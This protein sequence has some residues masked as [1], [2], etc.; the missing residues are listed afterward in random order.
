MHSKILN[1]IP[2][3]YLNEI[4]QTFQITEESFK[5]QTDQFNNVKDILK[6]SVEPKSKTVMLDFYD[7]SI[8]YI[9]YI[10][11]LDEFKEK[12]DTEQLIDD[13]ELFLKNFRHK[14]NRGVQNVRFRNFNVNLINTS[15]ILNNSPLR[16]NNLLK[17]AH[18][19]LMAEFEAFN[20]DYFTKLLICKPQLM[21]GPVK[22]FKKKTFTLSFEQII[23]YHSQ[24]ALFTEMVNKFI[25]NVPSNIDLFITKFLEPCL[26]IKFSTHYQ[27]WESLRE[28]YY[29]RNAIVHNNGRY[30]KNYINNL[31]LDLNMLNKQIEIDNDYLENCYET[32]ISYIKFIH[33]LIVNLFPDLKLELI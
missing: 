17:M 13:Y 14:I 27:K 29:R 2:G 31:N 22:Y 7:K 12:L 28:S 20:H 21:N 26:D 19:Y 15:D 25:S 4:K 3:I 23:E 1:M 11:N 18:I 5:I 16:I 6:K 10:E 30:S 9:Q 32:L 24:E 8:I 33:N